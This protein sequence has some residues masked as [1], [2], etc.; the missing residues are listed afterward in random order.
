MQLPAVVNRVPAMADTGPR[1]NVHV[2]PSSQQQYAEVGHQ[3][4][5]PSVHRA[6][7]TNVAPVLLQSTVG[8]AVARP[9]DETVVPAGDRRVTIQ[10]QTDGALRH[11]MVSNH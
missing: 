8:G 7:H 4:A 5:G 2:P 9:R 11:R 6:D 10:V 1:E 3:L